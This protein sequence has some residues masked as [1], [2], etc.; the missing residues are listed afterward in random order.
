MGLFSKKVKTTQAMPPV[1]YGIIYNYIKIDSINGKSMN[2][3]FWQYGEKKKGLLAGKV[4]LVYLEQG[5]Y[6][7]IAHGVTY[8]T[9]PTAIHIEIKANVNYVLGAN[10]DELYCC[11]R[12]Y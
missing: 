12:A 6:E 2:D 1:N 10:E 3:F 8:Q 11:E 9:N 5:E 7:I 4:E